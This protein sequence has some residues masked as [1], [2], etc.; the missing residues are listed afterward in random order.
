MELIRNFE[1]FST[2]CKIIAAQLRTMVECTPYPDYN[3]GAVDFMTDK[4]GGCYTLLHYDYFTNVVTYF[5]GHPTREREIRTFADLFET[6][7]DDMYATLENRD[8]DAVY[9]MVNA[10]YD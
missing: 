7:Q 6:V 10:E 8:L 2:L 1:E 3:W 9:E 5:K 4:F